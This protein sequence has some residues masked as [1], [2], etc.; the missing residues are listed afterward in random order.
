MLIVERSGLEVRDKSWDFIKIV[1]FQDKKRYLLDRGLADEFRDFPGNP[2][3]LAIPG[4]V[5]VAFR[6]SCQLVWT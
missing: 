4:W 6:Y 3:H 2:G 5:D 1:H